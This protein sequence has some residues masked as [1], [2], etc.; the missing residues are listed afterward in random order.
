[1]PAGNHQRQESLRERERRPLLL[2]VGGED[3]ALQV[4][5]RHDRESEAV[6]EALGAGDADQQRADESRRAR[7]GD[8]IDIGELHA[9]VGE[10]AVHE[11]KE[12]LQM[13][14]RRDLRHHAAERLMALDLRRDVVHAHAAVVVHEGHGRLIARRFDPQN[15]A[16]VSTKPVTL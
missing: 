4:V 1:M 15:H 14:A 7:D 3:V 6:G 12:V 11:R 2:Q 8:G 10:R 9:S 13:L 5:D 16:G